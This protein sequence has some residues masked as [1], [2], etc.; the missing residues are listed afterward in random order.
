MKRASKEKEGVRMWYLLACDK[1][2]QPDRLFFLKQNES[3]EALV[4]EAEELKD[5][6]DTT[7]QRYFVAE[8]V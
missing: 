2:R 5:R 4:E 6:Q 1:E 3:K 7:V 8:E